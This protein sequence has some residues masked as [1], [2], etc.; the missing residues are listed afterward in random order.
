M[1]GLVQAADAAEARGDAAAALEIISRQLLDEDGKLFWRPWRLARLEQLVVLEPMLPRWA[2]SRWI[3]DQAAQGLDPSMRRGHAAARAVAVELR[4]G[5]A[6]LPGIDEVD[7]M[8]RVMDNDW[9]YRQ[10][11]LFDH[12][13][14]AAFL[15]RGAAADLVAGADRI[16]EWVGAPMRALRFESRE[17]TML[18]WTDLATG[19]QVEVP[20]LG[21]AVLVL[22]GEHVIGR[23]VPTSDGPMFEGIPLRVPGE[24]AAAVATDPADWVG[25]LKRCE[26]DHP[27]RSST[28]IVR[29]NHL[30]SDVPDA[31]WRLVVLSS[32]GDR[33]P[34]AD[35]WDDFTEGAIAL[36]RAAM[37]GEPEALIDGDIEGVDPW[38][39]IAAMLCD[40]RSIELLVEELGPADVP[41]LMALAE[42]LFGP[43]GAVCRELAAAARAA[44]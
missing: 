24:V 7:A 29:G 33:D 40:R 35:V 31:V 23:L 19:E 12:G 11:L 3:L 18:H 8:S 21:A 34:G 15:R 10:L 36:V 38:P 41:A 5:R 32:I 20:N 22:P 16:H 17:P 27:D 39:C 4:G 37:T 28:A 44:A 25:A 1:I 13:G 2:I 9:V 42:R 43:G 6:A 30:V 26:A 14:L